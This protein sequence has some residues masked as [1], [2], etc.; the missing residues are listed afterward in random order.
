M[1]TGSPKAASRTSIKLG[2][3]YTRGSCALSE[4]DSLEGVWDPS[5]KHTR[6]HKRTGQKQRQ[7]PQERASLQKQRA[8]T[9][10]SQQ[11]EA[12]T[13]G[14]D[15][16]EVTLPPVK[17]RPTE[18]EIRSF[19][20]LIASCPDGYFDDP[21]NYS[22]FKLYLKYALRP[23]KER[24]KVFNSTL[25]REAW[26]LQQSCLEKGIDLYAYEPKEHGTI[27]STIMGSKQLPAKERPRHG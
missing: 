10:T 6:P 20:K 9:N 25:K 1:L 16:S 12:H 8:Q 13:T 15:G 23:Y 11:Q 18:A 4:E 21:H 14:S 19:R 22:H 24:Y 7:I 3:T 17:F 27:T 2:S 26:L 5:S